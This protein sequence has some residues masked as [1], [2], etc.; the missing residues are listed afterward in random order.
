MSDEQ[1][2]Q[3][4]ASAKSE[5]ETE[6]KADVK[7]SDYPDDLVKAVKAAQLRICAQEVP[8]GLDIRLKAAAEAK[9]KG[10]REWYLAGNRAARPVESPFLRIGRLA[11][12]EKP[13]RHGRRK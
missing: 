12:P 13:A 7:V 1:S 6:S 9:A 5:H 4:D 2:K 3:T 10:V 11:E 8:E